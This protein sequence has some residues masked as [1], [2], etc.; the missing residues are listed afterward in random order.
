MI[1]LIFK[2][3]ILGLFIGSSSALNVAALVKAT[4]LVKPGSILVTFLPDAGYRHWSSPLW[5]TF[6]LQNPPDDTNILSLIL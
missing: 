3:D 6:P 1:V 4:R 2:L 5:S